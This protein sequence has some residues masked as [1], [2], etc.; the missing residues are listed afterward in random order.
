MPEAA[1]AARR[2]GHQPQP[3][4]PDR[5]HPA[6]TAGSAI[7][8][9]GDRHSRGSAARLS[10]DNTDD[11]PG[12]TVQQQ[13]AATASSRTDLS[14]PPWFSDLHERP[15]FCPNLFQ[16][17]RWQTTNL[18]RQDVQMETYASYAVRAA[19][20]DDRSDSIVY[21]F[22]PNYGEADRVYLRIRSLEGRTVWCEGII[23]SA[24]YRKRYNV[25][26][27][28][29]RFIPDD[30]VLS[31]TIGAWYRFL[32]N[33][34]K[35]DS[36]GRLIDAKLDIKLF[37]RSNRSLRRWWAAIRVTQQ[38]PVSTNRIAMNLALLGVAL[39]IISLITPFL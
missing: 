20:T 15:A 17:A 36:N 9:Q 2:D 33:V 23:N 31:V 37:E 1:A 18:T 35:R 39:G 19:M 7:N 16:E 3:A 10:C 38:H 25:R 29:R 26:E 4:G 22:D 34:D 8:G 21:V 12:H 30:P 14:R 24:T 27:Q 11:L 32:L 28:G 13:S 5:E 6:G